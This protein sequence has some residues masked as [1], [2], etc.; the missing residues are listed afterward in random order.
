MSLPLHSLLPAQARERP[1]KVALEYREKKVSYHSLNLAC[2]QFAGGCQR[3]G[4]SHGARIGVYLPRCIEAVVAFFGALQAG[5]CLVPVNPVLKSRQ[6]SHI[7][8]D[9]GVELL[10]TTSSRLDTLHEALMHD[11]QLH[12]VVVID[13]E[14]MPSGDPE[15]AV[16]IEGWREFCAR[17]AP[18]N[19]DLQDT[20]L[21]AIFYTSGSTGL[22]K[23]VMLTHRNLCA[24]AESVTAYL[25]NTSRDRILSVLPFSFDYG[26]SQLSTAF[27][28][29]AT[30]VILDYLLPQDILK[31]IGRERI[32]GLAGVPA[33]WQQLARLDWPE[34]SG[35]T[36]RY[37]T[38]SGD[39]LPETAIRMLTGKL[40]ATDLYLMYGFTEAFRSTYLPPQE[41]H[42]RPTSIG[43]AIPGAWVR[44]V[45]PDGSPC[46][47]DEVGELVHGGPLVAQG[48]WNHSVETGERFR[49]LAT[50]PAGSREAGEAV[51]WSGDLVRQDQDGYFYFVGRKDDMIKTSGYRVSPA[52]I[53]GPACQHGIVREAVAFGVTH[54]QRGQSIVLTCT[55]DQ[56]PEQAE[57]ELDRHLKDVLPLYMVPEHYVWTDAIPCN[58]NGKFDRK[59]LASQYQA[60]VAGT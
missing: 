20:D 52:E 5:A 34:A 17:S 57:A 50:G 7:L 22:P 9:C 51:A 44:V 32:T 13:Q 36:L 28:V 14:A 16:R 45:R 39:V 54:P 35:E 11:S 27:S 48:Y 38:S 49:P 6:A 15:Q 42:Q 21:A 43:K 25:E 23:G 41:I 60:G 47:P 12:T 18:A 3:V 30:V 24:G 33:L 53:E 26:F 29:G 2:E 10:V 8:E 1:D 56:E 59:R 19:T 4:L 31:A 55:T 40:P 46:D 37:I 58:D